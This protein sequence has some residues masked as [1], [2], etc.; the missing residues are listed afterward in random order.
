PDNPRYVLGGSY[1]GTI[2]ALDMQSKASTKIMAAPIQYLG[3][4][5][6]D[7][8]YLY[9]WNAPII[10]SQHEPNT[11]YHCAQLVLRTR[12]MGMTWEEVSPDLTR[13]M[14][15]KQGK[16]GGPYTV[17]AVGAEN[18]GTIPYMIDSPHEK[19]VFWTG[20]DD[21]FVNITKDNGA[22]W[23]NVTPKGLQECLVNAIEV[24]PHDPATAYIAT[25][26]YKFNDYT[27]AIYK[28]TDYGKS[29][30]NISTGIPY[31]A[32]TRVVR[33]DE[34]R[35]DLLYAGTEKGVYISWNGGKSWEAFQLNLPKTPITDLKVHKGNLIVATSGRSFWI[36][37]DLKALAQYRDS[38]N[39]VAI[40]NPADAMNGSWYSPLSGNTDK[41]KGTHPYNGVNPANGMV[42]YYQLPKLSDS[43]HISLEILNSNG[44]LVRS[45]S[46]QR[47]KEAPI[48]RGGGPP[49][50]PLLSKKEG[51]NRFVWD[52]KYPLLPGIPGVYMEA[53]FRGHLAPPGSYTLNL[54]VD[55]KVAT[56]V[57]KIVA[58]PSY[59]TK[60]GQ[61]AE[62]DAFMTEME[63]NLTQMHDQVNALFKAQ[64][65]LKSV[66]AGLKDDALKAAGKKLFEQMEAWDKNMVQRK[67]K[68]YD[69]VENFPNKFTAEYLFLIDATNSSIPR[70]N[71]SSIDRKT[72]LD[73][74]WDKLSQE[75]D[76]LIKN[77]IPAY[78][79][80]LWD[81]DI[82][83]IQVKD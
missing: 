77:A 19:G 45:F 41:F 40:L 22:T 65:Q 36:L 62:Y 43:T 2:E 67:S 4:A 70:V 48:F 27:P 82:G 42:I 74:Q 15:D 75:A 11:F 34:N 20:S 31:G 39:E 24:S 18:Y 46:S 33:E 60:A 68:A 59:E 5:A 55:E 30:T 7:M 6:R 26:R 64:K 73:M 61:Y 9:N 58:V 14:D 81:A 29:W 57:G 66:I 56:T 38:K 35:S 79:K 44:K 17:E 83:A 76:R 25:T 52:M 13:N 72:E 8:K 51:L 71:R 32:F 37:D 1:L 49:Q 3:R 47:D 12:D 10:K 28:T 16:G 21:G 63:Q 78:N 53:R 54:K 50:A 23:Q 69:D 80:Q